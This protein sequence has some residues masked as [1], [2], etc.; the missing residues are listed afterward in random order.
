M[1]RA[2]SFAEYR[3]YAARGALIQRGVMSLRSIANIR[4]HE[5]L[6]FLTDEVQVWHHKWYGG[7]RSRGDG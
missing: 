3:D 5:Q 4:L 1:G 6:G 7:G 2:L